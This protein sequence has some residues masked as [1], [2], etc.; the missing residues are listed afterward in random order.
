MS[1]P[2]GIRAVSCMDCEAVLKAE[3]DAALV[4]ALRKHYLDVHRPVP[5]TEDRI[6]EQI[7]AQ[8]HDA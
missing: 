4:E 8:A 7:S 5:M 3:N 2:G 6:R 1:A